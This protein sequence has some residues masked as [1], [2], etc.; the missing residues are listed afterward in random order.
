MNSCLY[1]GEEVGGAFSG[2]GIMGEC[3]NVHG[4][5]EGACLVKWRVVFS[6]MEG[7]YYSSEMK[8]C[9]MDWVVVYK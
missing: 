5:V 1:S 6:G 4:G 9:W 3:R 7:A 8:T 2:E